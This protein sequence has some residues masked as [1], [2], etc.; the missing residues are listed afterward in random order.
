MSPHSQVRKCMSFSHVSLS[1][2]TSRRH[3]QRLCLNWLLGLT[4]KPCFSPLLPTI[5]TEYAE[6][7]LAWW[8]ANQAP[9]LLRVTVWNWA[10]SYPALSCCVV[11]A[12][13]VMTGC[14]HKKSPSSNPTIYYSWVLAFYASLPF[15]VLCLGS[16]LEPLLLTFDLHSRSCFFILCSKNLMVVQSVTFL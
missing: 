1:L 9:G 16:L 8:Q 7:W 10:F 5:Y 15:S 3:N 12:H 4:L 14:K 2:V 11:R 13:V 6:A